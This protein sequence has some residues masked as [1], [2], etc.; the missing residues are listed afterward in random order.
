MIRFVKPL[1]QRA[2]K[3]TFLQSTCDFRGPLLHFSNMPRQKITFTTENKAGDCLGVVFGDLSTQKQGLIVIH[4]W[5]GMNDQIQEEGEMI[6][7][8]SGLAVFVPDFYRGKVATDREEAG[9]LMSGLDFEGAVQDIRG[10]AKWLLSN[11]CNKVGVCGF[12]MGGALSF[13]GAL[14]V[15]EISAAAPFYGIPS[16]KEQLADLKVPIQAHFAKKDDIV[17]FSSPADYIPLKE[18]LEKSKVDFEFYE[19]DAG[20]AFT[21]PSGP[22]GTYN[23]E[24]CD[25]AFSRMY[26]FMK[27]KLV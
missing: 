11:G 10:A 25:L 9:H 2:V 21:N 27:K 5:W 7:K 17:G 24:A 26:E 4:E 23:K 15:P 6:N 13:L 20:H 18:I 16:P 22:L 1:L 3:Q 19:Y 8:N 14:K 12:C